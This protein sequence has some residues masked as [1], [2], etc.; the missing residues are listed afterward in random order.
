MLL[1]FTTLGAVLLSTWRAPAAP[2]A[3]QAAGRAALLARAAA[4]EFDT[5]YVAPP[6]DPLSHHAALTSAAAA[7]DAHGYR[8][9]INGEI[10]V[11]VL[12]KSDVDVDVLPEPGYVRLASGTVRIDANGERGKGL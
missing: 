12:A 2:G 4:V 7:I 1:G 11:G 9:E 6:G 10:T 5:P 8:L 3:E